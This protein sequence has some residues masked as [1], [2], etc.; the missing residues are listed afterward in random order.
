MLVFFEHHSWQVIING[1]SCTTK[2][3]TTGE[4]ASCLPVFSGEDPLSRSLPSSN[5]QSVIIVLHPFVLFSLTVLCKL[6]QVSITRLQQG[7][8][9]QIPILVLCS[10]TH[11]PMWIYAGHGHTMNSTH[12]VKTTAL[13]FNS[14]LLCILRHLRPCPAV[15]HL[16]LKY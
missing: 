8:S 16:L 2:S 14:T 5:Q 7:F 13:I 12:P 6:M 4:W 11:N 1:N 3:N 15:Q 9:K 10:M